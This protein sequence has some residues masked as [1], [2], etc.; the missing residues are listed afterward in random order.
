MQIERM[1]AREFSL[2]EAQLR[3]AVKLLDEGKTVPFIAR[4]RKEATGGMDD[5]TLQRSWQD[6]LG[7][8]RAL[9]KRAARFAP[10]WRR[11]AR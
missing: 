8:L 5:Q 7:A 4:Y 6:R 9:E 11:R 1:L 3:G 2:P 10:R